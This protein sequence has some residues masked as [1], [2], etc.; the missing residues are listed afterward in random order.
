MRNNVPKTTDYIGR[1]AHYKNHNSHH[2]PVMAN[3]KIE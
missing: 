1:Y 2:R 3:I